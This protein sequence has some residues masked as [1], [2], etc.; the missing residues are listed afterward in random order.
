MELVVF[1]FTQLFIRFQTGSVGT[2]S[3]DRVV[4]EPNALRGIAL[5]GRKGTYTLD[6][7]SALR[8]EFRSG[9][10]R[11]DVQGGGPN[12]LVWLVGKPGTPDIVLALTEDGAGRTVGREFGAL[13]KLPA[14]GRG[15]GAE[16]E[17]V[18]NPN[19]LVDRILNIRRCPAPLVR[20]P[21]LPLVT[22][23]RGQAGG[24]PTRGWSREIVGRG[25]GRMPPTDAEG[26]APGGARW[27]RADVELIPAALRAVSLRRGRAA[28]AAAGPR[29]A[30]RGT[31]ESSG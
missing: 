22:L 24:Q 25:V 5:P 15:G 30:I 28:G 26:R 10:A 18:G 7:F 1:V 9:P 12:E 2:L 27:G 16:R 4:I 21:T 3:S 20:L 19:G 14:R 6:R 11:P 17:G 23:R 29:W 8:V 31:R 13:L